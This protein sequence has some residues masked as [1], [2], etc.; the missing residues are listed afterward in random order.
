M[1]HLHLGEV[2]ELHLELHHS[3]CLVQL[4]LLAYFPQPMPYMLDKLA[5]AQA[6]SSDSQ[7]VRCGHKGAS[8]ALI[9]HLQYRLVEVVAAVLEELGV[10]QDSS[11]TMAASLLGI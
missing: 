10:R 8:W 1:V 4:V 3:R 5:D 6:S 2:L 7:D 11:Q 9:F